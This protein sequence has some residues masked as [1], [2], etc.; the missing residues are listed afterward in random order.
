MYYF[1]FLK[2]KS[3]D[4]PVMKDVKVG[5]PASRRVRDAAESLLCALVE[6]VDFY[7]VHCGAE[8][9]CSTIDEVAYVYLSTGEM[10]TTLQASQN[11]R[12]YV[13]DNNILLGIYEDVSQQN[14]EQ[15][16]KVACILRG[17][18]S[19][20]AWTMQLRHLPRHR[21]GQKSTSSNPGRPLPMEDQVS[22]KSFKASFFPESIDNIPLC[23]A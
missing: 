9:L 1:I 5:Q 21:S 2:A 14:Y 4:P 7:T 23:K 16:A 8:S 10:L 3:S 19:R 13:L 18:A 6:Q 17:M 12:Y 22:K 20:S 11:F 15:Q